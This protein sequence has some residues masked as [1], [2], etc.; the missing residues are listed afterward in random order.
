MTKNFTPISR[1]TGS[2]GAEMWR[3]DLI[4]K[5]SKE[6]RK[7]KNRRTPLEVVDAEINVK[8]LSKTVVPKF[9]SYRENISRMDYAAAIRYSA[10][11]YKKGL[12]TYLPTGV[13]K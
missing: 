13:L 9:N 1:Q 2:I 8:N 10:N 4:V 7:R 11:F 12:A 3:T 5:L 6:S